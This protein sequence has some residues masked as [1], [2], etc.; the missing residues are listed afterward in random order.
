MRELARVTALAGWACDF[1]RAQG[2]R[3]WLLRACGDDHRM[4]DPQDARASDVTRTL[5]RRR[6]RLTLGR[7]RSGRGGLAG[8][9][10]S[11]SLIFV[12]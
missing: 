3:R 1:G 2:G 6:S 5:C 8:L 11:L 10:A 4:V 9:Q 7:C 12:S